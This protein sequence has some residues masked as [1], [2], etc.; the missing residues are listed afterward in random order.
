MLSL[1]SLGVLGRVLFHPKGF[2][3]DRYPCYSQFN[4]GESRVV[5]T[6]FSFIQIFVSLCSDMLMGGGTLSVYISDDIGNSWSET[7]NLYLDPW[8][9]VV[10]GIPRLDFV[11]P[12]PWRSGSKIPVFNSVA[13]S[14]APTCPAWIFFLCVWFCIDHLRKPWTSCVPL[15]VRHLPSST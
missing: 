15:K 7:H 12:K 10:R 14:Q 3:A 2:F 4:C 9:H 13:D 11:P 8:I 6:L 1:A 5:S